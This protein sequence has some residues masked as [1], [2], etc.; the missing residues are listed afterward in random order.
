MEAIEILAIIS[1]IA[2]ICCQICLF[3]I[4]IMFF[5]QSRKIRRRE[6]ERERDLEALS[7]LSGDEY[8][9]AYAEYKQKYNL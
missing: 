2:F 1:R 5:R 7:H 6:E 3:I 9:R 8:W 4:L